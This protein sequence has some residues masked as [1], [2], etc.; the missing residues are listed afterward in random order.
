MLFSD[1]NGILA[2]RDVYLKN[3]GEVLPKFHLGS[4]KSMEDDSIYTYSGGIRTHPIRSVGQPLHAVIK[5]YMDACMFLT[6]GYL[7]DV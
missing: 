4:G 5:L 3:S 2:A 6:P 1:P 7:E